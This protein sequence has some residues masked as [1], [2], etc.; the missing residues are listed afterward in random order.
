MIFQSG[1]FLF[2]FLPLFLL[3]F[4]AAPAGWWRNLVVLVFSY[5]FYSG[6]EPQFVLLLLFTSG[7]DFMVALR[8]A[9]SASARVRRVWLTTSIVLNLGL[10][11]F[12]KY[13]GMLLAGLAPLG[14]WLGLP[15]PGE[16][17]YKSFLLPAGL[18]FYTFQSMSYA[19]DVYRREVQPERSLVAFFSY[20]AYLPQLIAGP[21]ER[22]AAL[23]P[24]L[25]AMYQRPWDRSQWSAG[26]D[27]IALG[28]AQ[29]LLL[30]DGCGVLVDALAS[31]SS[32]TFWSAWGLGVGFG[33]QI[34]YDFAAYTHMAIGIALLMGVRLTENFLS[35]YQAP[36][37]Q[38]FWRRWHR[39]L[40][41]WFRDYLYIP[42]GGS[43]GGGWRTL[44][45]VGITFGLC[46]LWHGASWNF[47]VWGLWHG[48]LVGSYHLFRQRWRGV[49]LPHA[50]GVLLTFAAVTVGWVLFRLHAPGEILTVLKGMA[51]LNG[52]AWGRMTPGDGLLL[53]ALVGATLT[54]P[55][56]AVRWP[57]SS[58]WLE[59]A[60]LWG[61]ALAALF[62]SS[63]VQNFIYFQF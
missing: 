52:F 53:A 23:G 25:R 16:E 28:V 12:Y 61:V 3:C 43:Q 7:L 32:H 9:A 42:L 6:G 2:L 1:G 56:A 55:N 62:A 51:G 11:G 4:V 60:A 5:L 27:R 15:L 8:I 29:K 14:G 40:S 13:G 17:F 58:G 36:N 39:T 22:F 48:G 10:L 33:M 50:L 49:E 44:R 26:A 59:S 63:E 31:G 57:G 24:Q 41:E 18:S 46:G 19:I 20:V 21:I 34:Y 37:I 54:L 38:E 45:N 35:P 30:A 47:V